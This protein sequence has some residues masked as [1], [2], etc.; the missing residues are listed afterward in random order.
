MLRYKIGRSDTNDIVIPDASVSRQH[1]EIAALGGGRFALKDLG[2]TLGT[3]VGRDQS[4]TR[5]SETEVQGDTVI[6]F[7]E[8]ETTLLALLSDA[9][10]AALGLAP[11]P[12]AA[13]VAAELA[14]PP[15]D[16][17]MPQAVPPPAAPGAATEAPPP[18]EKSARPAPPTPRPEPAKATASGRPSARSAIKRFAATTGARRQALM[19]GLAAAG[20]FFVLAGGALAAILLLGDANAPIASDRDTGASS[21]GQARFLSACTSQWEI[22]ERRCRCFLTAAGATIQSEDYEDFAQLVEAYL[23][24]DADRPEAVLQQVNEKRGV[25]AH[26]RLAAAFRGVVRDC[27]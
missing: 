2:S 24:G 19:R 25:A 27:Q 21:Q 15:A 8:F 23:S 13:P 10:K 3:H 1:A 4:W 11:A 26:T 18:P 9:Q 17:S 22:E 20:V 5:V 16:K 12:P 14:P 7:G 6:R